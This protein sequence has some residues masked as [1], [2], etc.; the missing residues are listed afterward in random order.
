MVKLPKII[1]EEKIK[2]ILA[3]Y[4]KCKVQAQAARMNNVSPG[5]VC[6]VIK[7]YGKSK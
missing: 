6:K 5:Y 1:S 3:D 2:K 4:G 7:R